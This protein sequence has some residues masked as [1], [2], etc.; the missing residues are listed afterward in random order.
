MCCLQSLRKELCVNVSSLCDLKCYTK[1][2]HIHVYT[3]VRCD[4]GDSYNV[5]DISMQLV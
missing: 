5:R 2:R 3:Q 1:R 4:D